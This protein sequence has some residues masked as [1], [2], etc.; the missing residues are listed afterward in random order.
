MFS[1]CSPGNLN[2][3]S[4][5]AAPASLFPNQGLFSISLALTLESHLCWAFLK[6]PTALPCPNAFNENQVEMTSETEMGFKRGS[7]S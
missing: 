4:S 2:K 7:E 3:I 1:M 5:L 6:E